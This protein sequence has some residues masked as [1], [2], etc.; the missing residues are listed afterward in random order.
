MDKNTK[1]DATAVTLQRLEEELKAAKACVTDLEEQI[2]SLLRKQA[3]ER[4]KKKPKTSI[5]KLPPIAGTSLKLICQWLDLL[6]L[7]NCAQVCR[8]WKNEIDEQVVKQMMETVLKTLAYCEMEYDAEWALFQLADAIMVNPT[9]SVVQYEKLMFELDGIG[10]ILVAMSRFGGNEDIENT[11]LSLL[12]FMAIYF[13][14]ARPLLAKA[15]LP[16]L[17]I[18]MVEKY[19]DCEDDE[20]V[21]LKRTTGSISCISRFATDERTIEFVTSD[22]IIDFVLKAMNKFGEDC[23]IQRMGGIYCLEVT[24]LAHVNE[25]FRQKKHKVGEVVVALAKAMSHL[26]ES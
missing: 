23:F 6:D 3:D 4:P 24:E 26:E 16:M 21:L 15:G 18:T 10:T 1:K 5:V 9:K 12:C 7:A 20:N 19:N 2:E 8:H 14:K 11:V 25:S 17:A 13:P 22:E